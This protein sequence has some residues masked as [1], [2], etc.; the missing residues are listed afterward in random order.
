MK[1]NKNFFTREN[2]K[3]SERIKEGRTLFIAGT[4]VQTEIETYDKALRKGSYYYD[5]Y[6][7]CEKTKKRIQV[8][9]AIPK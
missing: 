2:I 7:D 3:V 5:V 9:F 4:D 1:K 8:G 6:S